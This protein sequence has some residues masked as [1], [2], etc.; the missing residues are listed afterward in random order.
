MVG[1]DMSANTVTVAPGTDHPALYTDTLATSSTRFNWIGPPPPELQQVRR[2]PTG[3]RA[4]TREGG[5]LSPVSLI[6]PGL[7][8][9]LVDR[10]CLACWGWLGQAGGSFDCT[11]R[12][13]Y[14]Q[15]LSRC[16]VSV[17]ASGASLRVEFGSPQ[18]AVAVGQT[19]ALYDQHGQR[20]LGGGIISCCG[21]SYWKQGKPLPDRLTD[22]TTRGAAQGAQAADEDEQLQEEEEAV[23]SSSSSSR[24]SR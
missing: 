1:K 16:R 11:Y 19:V 23:G 7:A 4:A 14:R 12:V 20:C 2:R 5:L 24:H 18:R 6:C 22:W 8:G 17:E 10:W 13:R 21:P 9:L 15:P 3:R